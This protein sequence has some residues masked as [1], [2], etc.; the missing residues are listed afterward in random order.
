MLSKTPKSIDDFTNSQGTHCFDKSQIK[1]I[2]QFFHIPLK[3]KKCDESFKLF[4]DF[5]SNDDDVLIN[6]FLTL[7]I[8]ERFCKVI[9]EYIC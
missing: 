4:E 7:E 5:K 3:I 8:F 6:L 2:F 1:N 9:N